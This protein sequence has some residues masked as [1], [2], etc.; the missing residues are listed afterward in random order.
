M[1]RHFVIYLFSVMTA[2]PLL[3]DTVVRY[4][5]SDGLSSQVDKRVAYVANGM[6]RVVNTSGRIE[7]EAI[8][9]S[10][11]GNLTLID[12]QQKSY[13]KVNE[14]ELTAMAGQ[15]RNL[16]DSVISE[17]PFNNPLVQSENNKSVKHS[18]IQRR[19]AGISCEL[20]EIQINGQKESEVCIAKS[21][22]LDISPNDYLT[23]E[24]LYKTGDKLARTAR[25]TVGQSLG[26]IPEFGAGDLGGLP[27]YI[28]SDASG[29]RLELT[30]TEID[31]E[32]VSAEYFK[33]P[34]GYK[35]Q[36]L[37]SLL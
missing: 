15:I 34:D 33:I 36:S 8:F 20:Y 14:A 18:G 6:V 19:V 16:I 2:A 29:S 5:I 23:L 17:L 35:Q 21:N 1:I 4:T 31:S 22:R 13:I 26:P 37:P 28:M 7:P 11:T 32:L 25:E 12:H 30:L 24:N 10:N 3:A 27:V 9:D